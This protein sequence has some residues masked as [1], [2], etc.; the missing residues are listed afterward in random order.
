MKETPMTAATFRP[1]GPALGAEVIGVDLTQ[2]I[3]ETGFAELRAAL[4][5]HHFLCLRDQHLSESQ[6]VDIS[7][8]FGPLETFP[9]QQKT[10]ARPTFYN[11]ANVTSDGALMAT[12]DPRLVAQKAN[13]LWHTDSSY[14]FV[15]SFCSLLYA[16]EALPDEAQDGETEFSN[17]FLA[18]DALP[19][20]TKRR[21][22]PLHMVHDYAFDY[23]L[24][25]DLPP[26]APGVREAFPPASHP[27]VR[28]HPDRGGRRSLFMTANVGGEIGGMTVEEG[29]ALHAELVAHVSR[30]EFCLRHRWRT[31]DLMVWDNRCLLHRGRPYDTQRFR[32]IARRTTIAGDGPVVGPFSGS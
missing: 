14:R 25:P 28:V 10:R 18:Y 23:R 12:T 21:I 29:R 17:M 24:F 6:Q 8:R 26:L 11:V 3:D 16:I 1:L 7:I 30:P 19:E 27:L 15:P 13:E 9:E 4:Q 5:Q 31:G 22:E 20:Q 2:A 32:R